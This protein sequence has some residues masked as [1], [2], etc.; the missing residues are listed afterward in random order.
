[1]GGREL[2]WAPGIIGRREGGIGQAQKE[3]VFRKGESEHVYRPKGK[4]SRWD[5]LKV[6]Q[7][8]SDHC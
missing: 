6:Q 5:G 4:G 7:Q 8:N 1:M 2:A 3:A